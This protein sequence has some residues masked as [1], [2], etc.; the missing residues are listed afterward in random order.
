MIGAGRGAASVANVALAMGYRIACWVDP[1]PRV[2]RCLG[3][4]VVA[5]MK[6]LGDHRAYSFALAIGDN[7]IRERVAS[8]LIDEHEDID[9]PRLIHPSATVSL[10]SRIGRGSVVMPQAV[11]GPAS[12][13]GRFCLLNTRASIDHDSVMKDFSSLAPAAVTGGH[14]VIGRRSA[15]SIGAVIKHGV[16]VGDDCVLG[17]NSYLNKDLA[18]LQLAYGS[19]ARVVR[20]RA[21][22]EPYLD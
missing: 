10:W 14:V 11:V 18:P 9:F 5:D 20:Q 7:A 19:P 15:V 8:R 22:G 1:E 4:E 3:Y 12:L 13:V 21:Q 17:A 6:A 2:K 16:S